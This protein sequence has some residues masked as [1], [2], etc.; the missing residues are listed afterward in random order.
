MY[1]L[2]PPLDELPQGDW[3]CP[4]CIAAANDAEDIGFNS[5]KTFTVEQFKDDCA[6]FDAQFFGQ[7]EPPSVADI[8][9]AF[10]KMV[11]E[12]SGKS[13][14]VYYGADL[15]TS[16]H[17]SAFPRTWDPDHG[18]GKRPDEYNAAAEHPWNLNNLPSAQ[19]EHPSLLRQVN[20]HIPGVIVP[21]LYVGS[22]FSS[23]C[24]HFED[25]MLYSVN[26]NHVGAAKTWYGVPGASADAFEECFKQAMP[27]LFAAQPDLL[28]QLV[29]M[30]SPSL[31]VSEGVPVYRTDQN[32]GEFVV[33]FP[34]SYHGGFNTGF[35]VAEAVNFAPPDW[36]RFG[37]DGVERYRLYRKPSVLCH[38]ELLCVA[39]ADSPSEEVA[40]WLVGDLKRLTNEERAARE[41]LL[42]DGVVRTRRYTPKKLAAAAMAAK[43]AHDA[44]ASAGI[45]SETPGIKLESNAGEADAAALATRAAMDV[46]L[47]PLD[48]AESLLPTNNANG[49]YDREC[50]ICRYILHLSGVA[51]SCNPDRAACLRHCAELC[52][53]PNSHRVMFY[54][55]SIAQLERLCA[56]TERACGKRAKA[57]EKEKAFGAAKSRQ[58]RAAAWVKRAKDALEQ[59]SPPTPTAELEA[60]MIA[61]EEF[62]WAGT[63]MDDVRKVAANVS[64]AIALQK[65]LAI[66][67]RRIS[68]GEDESVDGRTWW[69]EPELDDAD[70]VAAAAA[71][72]PLRRRRGG[73]YGKEESPQPPETA[74]KKEPNPSS[75]KPEVKTE[76]GAEDMDVDGGNKDAKPGKDGKTGGVAPPRRM[77]LNR[78]RQLLDAAP[79]PLPPDEEDIFRKVLA[80]GEDLE[81]RVVS[82]LAETPNMNPKKCI[83]LAAEV[84]RGPIEITSARRLKE[85]VAAAHAWSERVRRALPGR[86]HRPARAELPTL[87]QLSELKAGAVNLPVQPNDLD[88]VNVAMEET[89]AWSTKAQTLMARVPA[90]EIDD[91]EALLEEGLDLPCQCEQVELLEAACERAKQW[92]EMTIK[93]DEGNAKLEKLRALLEEGEGMSVCPVTDLSALRERIRVREWADPA[94]LVAA[95]KPNPASLEDVRAVVAA[96]AAIIEGVKTPEKPPEPAAKSGKKGKKGGAKKAAASPEPSVEAAVDEDHVTDQERALLDRLRSNMANG[97]AWE[98]R[99]AAM[100]ADAE[101]GNLKPLEDVEKLVKEAQAIPCALALFDQLFE[102]SNS[103]RTWAEKAQLCLKGKQLT[104]RGAAAPPPTLAHAER[105]VRDAGKFFVQVKELQALTERVAEAKEWGESAEKAVERWK[106]E[107]A[108]QTFT[109]LMLDHER[110]GLELPA[111]ADVRACLAALEWEREVRETLCMP[112]AADASKDKKKSGRSADSS[113]NK[114]TTGGSS[115]P[116]PQLEVLEDLRERAK[117]IDTDDMDEALRDELARRL[118]IIDGWTEKVD[119]AMGLNDRVATKQKPA[120][121]LQVAANAEKRPTPEV[122]QELV[123][124]GK[125]LPAIVP[126]VTELETIL[127]E[128]RR[129]VEA[130]RKLLGPPKPKPSAEQLAAESAAVAASEAAD[131]AA[132]AAASSEAAAEAERLRKSKKKGKKGGKGGKAGVA[133]VG[134]VKDEEAADEAKE[135]ARMAAAATRVATAVAERL[136]AAK[137]KTDNRPAMADVLEMQAAGEG[138]PLKSEEGVELAAAA[139]ASS[140]WSERLRKLLI[141]PRS[142]AGVHAIA[143]DDSVTALKLI[144]QSI[145]AATAD[146]E[147]TGEPPESEEGQFCLCRQPGGREMLGCDVCGDWYHLRCAGVTATFARNAQ[148]YTCL[149]CLA[150]SGDVL[151]LNNPKEVYKHIHRTRRPALVSLGEMLLEAMDFSGKLSE[152]TLLAEVFNEHAAWRAAVADALERRSTLAPLEKEAQ[153]TAETANKAADAYMELRGAREARTQAVADRA[154]A[155]QHAQVLAGATAMAAALLG[156]GGGGTHNAAMEAAQRVAH[157]PPDQQLEALGQQ[158]GQAAAIKQ[159]QLMQLKGAVTAAAAA[160]L[161]GGNAD[162]ATV[163]KAAESAAPFEAMLVAQLQ[164]IGT[165]V[166][167]LATC[168]QSIQ[169]QIAAAPRA[170]P[171]S[172]EAATQQYQV[173]IQVMMMQ[174]HFLTLSKQHDMQLDA[175]GSGLMEQQRV[176]AAA[177]AAA[178]EQDQEDD[179]QAGDEA[180]GLDDAVKA[181]AELKSEAETAPKEETKTPAVDAEMT[182]AAPVEEAKTEDAETTEQEPK[183]EEEDPDVKDEERALLAT[184][185]DVPK[186]KSPT[187]PAPDPPPAPKTRRKK[188][189]EQPSEE[190]KE[191]E[192]VAMDLAKIAQ[193]AAEKLASVTGPGNPLRQ[194]FAGLKG[195]LAMEIDPNPLEPEFPS[196]LREVCGAAWRERAA[197]ALAERTGSDAEADDNL[198]YPTLAVLTELRETGVASGVIIPN[199]TSGDPPGPD[200]LGDR[201]QETEKAGQAWLDRAADAVD[202]TKGVPVEAVVA[203]MDEGRALPINLKDELEELGERCEVYC[204]CKTPY[205]ALRPM[206]SCDRCEGWFHYDCCGMRPP[207]E[208]EPEDA[209]VHFTCPTCCKS[210]GS[211]YK[212]FRPPPV[213]KKD[214][215]DDND[216]DDEE[217]GDQASESDAGV[218]EEKTVERSEEDLDAVA[219]ALTI[220]LPPKEEAKEEPAEP[221]P[222]PMETDEK[223]PTKEEAP[224]PV[225]E[226]KVEEAPP[227]EPARGGRTTR[228]SRR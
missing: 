122:I 227:E 93:A 190:E 107:G 110:F 147:G 12:G 95:G 121:A 187:P 163:A 87:D 126:R 21:W 116:L 105:L 61:A 141:R 165:F 170:V 120:S 218:D 228:R 67:K 7:D 52:E 20:D 48:D 203:L 182:E 39:A 103:A 184:D 148:K 210:N 6:K 114:K 222:E 101:A 221:A 204:L 153:R 60:I 173:M 73:K 65:E 167:Q 140:A 217:E 206:I 212:P 45:K 42:T 139:A 79:F 226:V 152:E 179:S 123:E 15:D 13:V 207:T 10:W 211:K 86:R 223:P 135:V 112:A 53:C 80:A 1:C 198:K 172:Q 183:K 19:G 171:G 169:Q 28:L 38:D 3:F 196:L 91:A 109:E 24:W 100:H 149:A 70:I 197:A 72:A 63:D 133:T 75:V 132:A 36:L 194:I 131:Q 108:E 130:A 25:H 174:Q 18:P 66:L 192:K 127:D 209:D 40:R 49:A 33:T 185:E 118:E 69:E 191:L 113:P 51:C 8:E 50:T 59:K 31:L 54:R 102:A 41:Q 156:A 27:D 146:L 88:S 175:L 160:G 9:E 158:V 43:N 35:N 138:L 22:T 57:S 111:A 188:S 154:A 81:S 168:Q 96:G 151:K 14:D 106:E 193:A 128:H 150:A 78:L 74:T 129:W 186:S 215:E 99:A 143:V 220:G 134:A 161:A 17:G 2:S 5:G 92:V 97:E 104:R 82:T 119:V 77:S 142:S 32:A 30:L 11:E 162:E 164:E 213:K 23:F 189:P 90:A 137:D 219:E 29:T 200:P 76:D 202:G 178:V 83:S 89:I 136:A 4:D 166:H 85:A 117:D 16:V 181:E 199:R 84:T 56:S 157:L 201:V 37:C 64:I 68:L 71:G 47:D 177:A 44:R 62:T 216:D 176:A 115:E 159:Q 46:A 180:P 125:E 94:K 205:D 224:A 26:Y 98:K 58:K 208:E 214:D 144:L 55:K 195:A 34:K 155:V 145:K 225:E 124:A